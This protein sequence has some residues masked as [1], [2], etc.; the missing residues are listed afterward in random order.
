MRKN[1]TERT[2]IGLPNLDKLLEG[3]LPKGTINLVSGAC[4]TGKTI[5]AMHFI[6]YGAKYLNEPGVYI[7]L[8]EDPEELIKNMRLFG[9]DIDDLIREKKIAIIRPVIYKFDSL[10]QILS[11]TIE[12]ISAK[13]I[14]VDSYSVLLGYFSD[15][16]KVR[17]GLVHLDEEIKKMGCTALIISDINDGSAILSASGLEEYIVDGVVVLYLMKK[18]AYPY[19]AFRALSIR[20]MR[21]T[22]HPL[23]LYPF[24][25]TDHGI[26]FGGNSLGDMQD[27]SPCRTQKAEK[28]G[29]GG[30]GLKGMQKPSHCRT[31][32]A[33][34]PGKGE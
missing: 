7:T 6:Y 29:K 25:I 27:P 34:K 10:K 13:R 18:P 1:P 15:L 16:Y 23:D 12:R 19:G 2:S 9:W 28:P 22:H 24:E 26:K 21:S 5:L 11:D 17:T 3:G 33:E 8:E 31:P 14:V 20:K 4:G 32:R 30:N